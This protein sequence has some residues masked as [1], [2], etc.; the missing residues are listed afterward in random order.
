MPDIDLNFSGEYQPVAHKYTEELF[1]RDN[2]CRAGTISTVASK[3]A[4]GYVR[5]YYE[6]KGLT[7]HP[8]YMAGLV[9]GIAGLKR[10]TGQHPGGIMVV[11]RNMTILRR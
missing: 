2:V 1:G 10:T 4:F 5:K 11:P 3:T 8:A 6:E 7:K 9:E